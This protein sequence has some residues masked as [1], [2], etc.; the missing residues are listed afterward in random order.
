M[1]FVFMIERG[2][3][4]TAALNLTLC[5]QAIGEYM[6]RMEEYSAVCAKSE[7]KLGPP[8]RMFLVRSEIC[9]KLMKKVVHGIGRAEAKFKF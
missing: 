6:V 3:L 9:R 2:A 1:K 4:P 8:L 5:F 7:P